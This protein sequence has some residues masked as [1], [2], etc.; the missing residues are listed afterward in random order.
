M[1]A[2]E[3]YSPIVREFS[4]G[5]HYLSPRAYDFLRNTFK[6]N[7]PH[8]STLRQWY[9]NAKLSD[10]PGINQAVLIKLKSLV[11]EKKSN[12]CELLVSLSSDEINIRK[13]VQ[14]CNSTKR[15]IG[16]ATIGNE[17][18]KSA[19]AKQALVFMVNGIN[20][21]LNLPVAHFYISILNAEGRMKLMSDVVIAIL[22]CGVTMTNITFDGLAANGK[23]CRLLGANLDVTSPDLN[24]QFF[25][26][27]LTAVQIMYDNSHMIKLIR[28]ALGNNRTLY[29]G[30]NSK[31]EWKFINELVEFTRTHNIKG[32]HKLSKAHMQWKRKAMKVII[33][34]QT[35]SES[36]ACAMEY[37]MNNGYEEFKDAAATIEF[38]RMFNKLFDI[39]NSKSVGNNSIF[40]DAI[41]PNN[42][43]AMLEF[44]DQAESYILG[45]KIEDSQGKLIKVVKSRV[46]TGFA[47]FIINI[48]SI[49]NIYNQFVSQEQ[50]LDN[51]PTYNLFQDPL[52]FFF[53]KIR[54]LNGYN[55]NPTIQQFSA[56]HRKLLVNA[57]IQSS[58]FANV[59]VSKVKI[60]MI[61]DLKTVSSRKLKNS[62]IASLA[63]ACVSG[64]EVSEVDLNVLQE[65]LPSISVTHLAS[66]IEQ[67]VK[68]SSLYCKE[69]ANVFIENEKT[70]VAYIQAPCQSSFEICAVVDKHMNLQ[71]LR[72]TTNFNDIYSKIFYEIQVDR[73]FVL[74]D[75]SHDIS[76]KLYLIRFIVD[77]YV[78][79][80]GTMIA[81]EATLNEHKQFYRSQFRKLVHF[82]NQ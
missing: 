74:T 9:A 44:F 60:S 79:I 43:N 46:R 80:K 57:N 82:Y 28:N 56:A 81:K 70:D 2:R 38:I 26:N 6:K 3:R 31:I 54:S 52:E 30:S 20:E 53:G 36:T 22:H 1:K 47:A 27:E 48:Q 64:S 68:S 73:M 75:F 29:N 78:H 7:L 61:N 15:L 18:E 39:I 62:K 37:F 49:K 13:N 51:I 24:S 65:S 8:V 71:I 42:V 67:K 21:N 23:M 34:V 58:S 5:L 12:G 72:K 55:D 77:A 33:A 14:W 69:C 16:Y 66:V 32:I 25:M 63:D 76:H 17:K 4:L 35:L 40:K 59:N 10:E 45:L 50:L 41:N 19:V 11:T